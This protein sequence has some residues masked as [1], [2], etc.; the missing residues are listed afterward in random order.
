MDGGWGGLGIGKTT[1]VLHE[2]VTKFISGQSNWSCKQMP[3]SEK[4]WV[5]GEKE[6]IQEAGVN[7]FIQ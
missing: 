3:H 4:G 1:G 2:P 6:K 5:G 7:V